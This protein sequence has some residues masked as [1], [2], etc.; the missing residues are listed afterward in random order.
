DPFDARVSAERADRSL[1]L[2]QRRHWWW[3]A[4]IVLL[5][6]VVAPLAL[7]RLTRRRWFS[8]RVPGPG[9]ELDTAPPSSLDPIGAAVLVAGARPVDAGAA[10]AGHVLDLVERRQL[11]MRRS[12]TT[13]PGL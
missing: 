12:T 13:P 9:T 2:A 1:L 5:A 3:V 4:P 10:L 6:G 8:M 11:P 7:W